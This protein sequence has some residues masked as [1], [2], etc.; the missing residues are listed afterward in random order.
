MKIMIAL[1]IVGVLA[2]P[3]AGWTHGVPVQPP[4][5]VHP[6]VPAAS[7]GGASNSGL[8]IFAIAAPFLLLGLHD[9]LY[10]GAFFCT[11][12]KGYQ[13]YVDWVNRGPQK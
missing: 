9:C 3:V 11:P 12:N 13:D 2:L 1:M 8:A 5:V 4:P 7:S 6:V 10:Y